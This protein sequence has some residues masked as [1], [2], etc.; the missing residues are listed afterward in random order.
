MAQEVKHARSAK[1]I[2]LKNQIRDEIL[3]EYIREKK[4][5]SVVLEKRWDDGSYSSHSD[6]F[7]E[8]RVMVPKDK[9]DLHGEIV[10]VIPVA[11]RDGVII[12]ELN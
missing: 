8:V 1:L 3:D 4:T 12:A 10:T 9:G 2:A 5:L 7:L 6:S 11:H